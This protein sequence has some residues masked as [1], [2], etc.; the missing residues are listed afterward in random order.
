VRALAIGVIA[1]ESA[2]LNI[3]D[4]RVSDMMP[5]GAGCAQPSSSR[6]VVYGL[7]PFIEVAGEHGGNAFGRVSHVTV[8]GYLSEGLT[9][10][11]GFGGVPTDVTFT[12]NLVR[13]EAPAI[14]TDQFAIN[15]RF[16][17]I[18]RV[19]GNTVTG[20]LCT[21]DG[22]GAD[23]I[24]EFQ[25]GGV[26]AGGASAGTAIA[27]NRV[28]NADIGIYQLASPDCCQIADNTLSDNRFFGIVI[29]DGDGATDSN[30]IS[31]GQIGIGVV[32]DA[33]DTTG[34]LR[35]N[36]ISGTSVAPARE[37]DCCGFT[38]TAIVTP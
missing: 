3:S 18:A 20:A 17:A 9:A 15:I 21:V 27:G 22:C 38:A 12:E 34:R 8:D 6:A 36:H 23:P 28:S 16:G 31:G 11:G 1:T 32:A 10:T 4:A 5:A 29:Q 19:T 25:S 35:D 7:P 24:L 33:M 13:P 14:A 2:T 30:A 26:L 37:L